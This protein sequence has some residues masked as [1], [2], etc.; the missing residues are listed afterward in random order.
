MRETAAM[1][2]LKIN[3]QKT[4]SLRVNQRNNTNFDIGGDEIQDIEKFTYLGSIVSSEGGTDQDIVARIGKATTAFHILRPIWRTRAI[5]VKTKL[6]IF[7]TNVKSVLLH[8]LRWTPQ[9]KR[10]RGRPKTTWRRSTEAEVKQTGMSWNQL[11]KV[12]K[13]RGRWRSLVDDLCSTGT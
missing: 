2:G 6:R 10:N 13:D 12:A 8:A 5:S 3:I 4:K 1:I 7:N 9:G 11:E